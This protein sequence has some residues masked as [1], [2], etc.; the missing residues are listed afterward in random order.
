MKKLDVMNKLSRAFYNVGFTLKKHSPEILVTAGVVGTVASTVMACRATR[1]IDPILDEAKER[2]DAVHEALEHPENLPEGKEYTEADSKKELT[3]IY[4]KT[5]LDL[6]KLYGP[7]V[8]VGAASIGMIITSHSILHDRY[9]ASAAAYAGI[10]KEFKEYRERVVERF[11]EKL[12]YELKHNVKSKEIEEIVKHEDGTEEIVKTIYSVADPNSTYHT[13]RIYDDGCLGWEKD[14]E[15]NLIFLKQTET[16]LNQK[17]EAEGRLYLNDVYRALG[18]PTTREGQVLGWKWQKDGGSKERPNYV[19]FGLFD[20]NDERNRAFINGY[21]RNVVLRFN[22][23]GNILIGEWED[24]IA[25]EPM[26]RRR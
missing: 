19:S 10:F 8:I 17:F 6:A 11:G 5:A 4:G 7:S 13:D 23:H 21:E 12:D 24:R 15:N 9:V 20:I 3:A 2:I 22:H 14:P 1:K 25:H 26:P 16:Y 18:F